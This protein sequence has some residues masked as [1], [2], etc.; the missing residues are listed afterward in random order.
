MIGAFHILAYSGSAAL[1]ACVHP[2][3]SGEDHWAEL[4]TLLVLLITCWA[5]S[6]VLAIFNLWFIARL[7]MNRRYRRIHITVFLTSVLLAILLFSGA[8]GP[9][10]WTIGFAAFGIPFLVMGQFFCLLALRRKLKG[11]QPALQ[12]EP[13]E[14]YSGI[15]CVACRRPVQLGV[16]LCPVCGWTQPDY[17][18]G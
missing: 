3:V 6:A 14:N 5:W 4:V 7:Q 17:E 2:A 13:E 16:R 15:R 9:S 8:F 12:T 18:A 1:L 10:L 11:D